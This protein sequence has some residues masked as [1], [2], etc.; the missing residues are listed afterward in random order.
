MKKI[1]LSLIL[2]LTAV[3]SV[4]AQ[5]VKILEPSI[6]KHDD[7][8][9]IS[10]LADI[11]KFTRNGKLFVIP[12]ISSDSAEQSLTPIIAMGYKRK[13]T[14]RRKGIKLGDNIAGKRNGITAYT[15]TVPFKSWMYDINLKIALVMSS[16]DEVS[17]QPARLIM[18]KQFTKPKPKPTMKEIAAEQARIQAHKQ[19]EEM[20]RLEARLQGFRDEVVDKFPFM[21]PISEYKKV[22]ESKLTA[23]PTAQSQADGLS[24]YFRVGR[25][26]IDKAYK[27]NN[28]ALATLKEAV[29]VIDSSEIVK[30]SKIIIF[31]AASPEGSVNRN[32]YLAGKRAE[33][34]K[35]YMSSFVDA[36][37]IET[38]NLGE[39][40]TE[41]RALVADSEMSYKTE[42]LN[43][44]DKM[45]N[46]ETKEA[47]LWALKSGMPY[48]YVY[49]NFY[50]KLRSSN[51]VHMFYEAK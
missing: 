7:S 10:F 47:K 37:F 32:K 44:I 51:C 17:K 14:D 12:V 39:N 41:L 18:K 26:T 16:C 42:T 13:I 33:A 27:T 3:I 24:V 35:S 8:L 21:Y 29:E 28:A 11:G 15:V 4:N 40:W 6:T 46:L 36:S 23:T 2:L 5:N 48:K 19:Q 49:E 50:P 9:R 30:H 20:K 25:H 22:R 1:I 34:M 38:V 31:G 45:E 43:I